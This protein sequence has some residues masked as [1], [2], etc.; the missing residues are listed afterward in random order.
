[1]S[2]VAPLIYYYNV[3]DAQRF[4]FLSNSIFYVNKTTGVSDIYPQSY[5]LNSDNSLNYTRLEEIGP[6]RY[7]ATGGLQYVFINF[8]VTAAITHVIL[9]HGKDLGKSLLREWT[10]LRGGKVLADDKVDIHMRLMSAYDEVPTSWYYTIYA[11]GIILNIIV[12]YVNHSQLPWWGVL[13]AIGMSSVLSLPLNFISAVTGTSFGLNVVAEMICGFVF[14]GYPV[15]NIYFKTLG[16][17][18]MNQAGVMAMDLKI[19][20][21]LKVPPRIVF[22]NQ[23]IGTVIG[24]IFNYI[25]NDT[26]IENKKDILLGKGNNVWSGASFQ[27]INSAAIT[28]GAIGPMAMFGP[29]SMYHIV[30]WAF[31][32]GFF[33][34]LPTWLLHKRFP[35]VGFDNV[36]IPMVITGLSFMPGGNSSYVTVSFVIMLFSQWYLKQRHRA[37]FVKHNYLISAALDSGTSLMAFFLA[38][39]VEGGQSGKS[40]PFPTWFGNTDSQMKDYCC[41]ECPPETYGD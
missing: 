20:H 3:W 39:A 25:V 16:F 10:K 7:P 15:A 21:Y 24:C 12:A 30:L 37:W 17:N 28:W 34:P 5:V 38:M 35:T 14:E 26:I 18:T 41:A 19:G 13:F 9:Y 32:I 27:T 29:R 11:I 40:Y 2:V 22:W 6:P 33:L 8:S 23:M 31:V 1:M 4:P 36:N